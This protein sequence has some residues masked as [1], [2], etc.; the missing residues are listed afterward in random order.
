[1][2]LAG[3]IR[4]W[5]RKD[6]HGE[7]D[8]SPVGQIF[9]WGMAAIVTFQLFWGWWI[10][11]LPVGSDKLQAYQVHSQIGV[12]ILVLILLRMVW[13]LMV[14]GP[15]NDADKPGW[16][17]VAAHALHYAFYAA[18]IGLPISGWF[19]WSSMASEQPLSLAGAAPW[20]QLPLEGLPRETRWAIM[21]WA[22]DVHF[23]LVIALLVM[24]PIHVGAALKHHFWDRDDVLAGMTP[25]LEP[26]PK[27]RSQQERPAGP[28]R[29]PTRPES[30]ARSGVG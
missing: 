26:L 24:I 12:L 29:K 27:R 8:Y 22:E 20:P 10:G 21:R 25:L 17:S 23:V 4:A 30:R 7:K 18:L 19:M 28:P 3:K 2:S 15:V 14:P 11:R 5:A 9:H 13:R 16:Q 1:M 6:T